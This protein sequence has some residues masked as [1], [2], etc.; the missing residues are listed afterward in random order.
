MALQLC[1]AALAGSL[2]LGLSGCQWIGQDRSAPTV[3]DPPR[4][5]PPEAELSTEELAMDR[6]LVAQLQ[7]HLLAV[8]HDPGPIDGLLGPN[9]VREIKAFQ[10]AT[11][12]IADGRI[13]ER[14]VA[15]LARDAA[16]HGSD[17]T[18]SASP[19]DDDPETSRIDVVPVD[20]EPRYLPGS[21]Y[22]YS[23]GAILV[24]AAVDGAQVRWRSNRGEIF[25]AHRNIL[26]P[27][28]SWSTRGEEGHRVFDI[29]PDSL[30]QRTMQAEAV[31]VATT[32]V[33]HGGRPES[34]TEDKEHWRCRRVGSETLT[35]I[36]GRFATEKLICERLAADRSIDLVR[37]WYYAPS[38]RHYVRWLDVKASG[39]H[40][41]PV[42]L[43]AIQPAVSGWPPAAQA[44]LN[45]AIQ[46][47]LES[48]PSGEEQPWS[49]SAVAPSVI[50]RPGGEIAWAGQDA[51]RRY[52]QVWTID[53][54]D[55]VFPT[56]A[57]RD[58]SGAWIF[59]RLAGS[60]WIAQ[61]GAPLDR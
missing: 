43:V 34:L 30:W 31:F 7:R 36:A 26:M 58:P 54:E 22:L 29:A 51:C 6:D 27:P 37:T 1:A 9:T 4:A 25:T 53:Q 40:E 2:I 24:V 60:D 50:I 55:W 56:L 28:L 10:Q 23:D 32:T 13:T 48:L 21:R 3:A 33:R 59:P 41:P 46:H 20:I 61:A 38:L 14:L 12:Q 57:C 44:G 18:H 5:P 47:A 45:W 17:A 15:E 8:G 11:G 16:A 49:S 19:A 39:P 52:R 42:D 35:V